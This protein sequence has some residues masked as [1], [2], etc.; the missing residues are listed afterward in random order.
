MVGA[1]QDTWPHYTKQKMGRGEAKATSLF[2]RKSKDL[3][4]SSHWTSG[5][6]PLARTVS[7]DH[8]RGVRKAA[9][10]LYNRGTKAKEVS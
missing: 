5:D 2:T 6:I 10:A 3:P 7:R 8:T 1:T 9:T 4:R